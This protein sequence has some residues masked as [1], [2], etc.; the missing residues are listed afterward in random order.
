VPRRV[1]ELEADLRKAGFRRSP[2]KGG[3]RN[4]SHPLFPGVV[5]ISGKEGDDAKPYQ[6]KQVAA[7][8]ERARG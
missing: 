1:R 5:T 7:A 2:G 4:Y 3:H 8:I 6:E